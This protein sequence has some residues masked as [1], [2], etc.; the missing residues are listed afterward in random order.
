MPVARTSAERASLGRAA[1]KLAPRASHADWTA[2]TD[3][4][5]PVAILERQALTRVP[6]LIPL[7]YGRMLV[8]PFT[9]YRGAAAIMAADLAPTPATGLRVQLCGDAHLSNFGGF[10]APDRRIV[11]DINDFDET[12]PGPWEWDLKRLAAS[13]EIA[14]RDRGFSIK[15]RRAAV[16]ASAREYRSRMRELAA[17]GGLE[18]WYERLDVDGFAEAAVRERSALEI[19]RA[20]K[21]ARGKDR[22]RALERL[23]VR[24]DEGLRFA[25]DPPLLVPIEDVFEGDEGASGP[26]T[27][28]AIHRLMSSYR[29]TLASENQRLFDGYRYVHAARKVVGVGSVGT[30]AWLALYTGRDERDP[31]FLQLKEAQQSVLAPF[32]GATVGTSTDV[33]PAE[34]HE[35][36]RVVVGQRLMQST[37]DILL[38]WMTADA[39]DGVQRNFYVR[40]YWDQKL[41]PRIERFDPG[42]LQGYAGLCGQ[43]LARGHAR[44]GDAIA[45]ASYLG[46]GDNFDRAIVSFA[47][48]YADQNER[49]YAALS[50]AAASGRIEVAADPA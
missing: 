14:G 19:Q 45:I 21:K 13:I 20:V 36:K 35:G 25:S 22:M 29:D 41:S 26:E 7:R 1:R 8:S 49:D 16:A 15:E 6:E 47:E 34:G 11:F 38:G 50:E 48:A 39:P 46:G 31:L 3:R 9:F 40:Q 23:T 24:T 17:L 2:P 42:V 12:H 18:L 10:A 27:E 43:T 44:S 4:E 28:Q 33:H 5:D 37:G 32:A 30:R